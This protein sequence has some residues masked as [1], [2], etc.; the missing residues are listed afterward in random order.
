MGRGGAAGEL[1]RPRTAPVTS[2][3]AAAVAKAVFKIGI[4]MQPKAIIASLSLK[5]FLLPSPP[6]SIHPLRHLLHLSCPWTGVRVRNRPTLPLWYPRV[7]I[8]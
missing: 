5:A 4:L 8:Q 1:T 2:A 3:K 6:S 7:P